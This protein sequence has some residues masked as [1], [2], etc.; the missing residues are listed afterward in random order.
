MIS[1]IASHSGM[2][3]ESHSRV[4]DPLEQRPGSGTEQ[5][6]TK[7]Q[8]HRS[9]Q[10]VAPDERSEQIAV[11]TYYAHRDISVLDQAGTWQ[12]LEGPCM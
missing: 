9:D 12:L 8:D 11:R 2:Q 1:P 10:Q 5:Y 3:E 4:Q 6:G 7:V